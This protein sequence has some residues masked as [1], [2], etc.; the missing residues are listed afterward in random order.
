M[1]DK[2]WEIIETTVAIFKPTIILLPIGLLGYYLFNVNW[3]LWAWG[4]A[5]VGWIVTILGGYL[6]FR[7]R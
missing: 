6:H 3:F 4:I 1:N 7:Y 5:Q 2:Q